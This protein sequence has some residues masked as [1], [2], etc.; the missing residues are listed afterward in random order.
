MSQAA[1]A[2]A[3][4]VADLAWRGGIVASDDVDAE[5]GE[6]LVRALNR[7]VDW[8]RVNE[9]R[10][11]SELLRDLKPELQDGGLLPELIGA[12]TY[13]PKRFEQTARWMTERGFLPE[14]VQYEDVVRS[15]K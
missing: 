12:E 8:L 5:T 10:Q 6:K 3:R 9:A 7:A 14:G 4:K 1:E 11:R 13:S 15:Q 2:G